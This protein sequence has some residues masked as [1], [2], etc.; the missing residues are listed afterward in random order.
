MILHTCQPV[1]LNNGVSVTYPTYY[2]LNYGIIQDL[3]GGE[4][5]SD[6]VALVP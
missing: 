5:G 4:S 1:I 3:G 6:F 2:S